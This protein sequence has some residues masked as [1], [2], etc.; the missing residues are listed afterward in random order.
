MPSRCNDRALAQIKLVYAGTMNI[1]RPN[2]W[3]GSP[4][5]PSFQGNSR[6]EAGKEADHLR[7]KPWLFWMSV[8]G[9]LSRE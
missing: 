9:W 4:I 3:Q 7:R 8:E 5:Y 1:P 2:I 6:D